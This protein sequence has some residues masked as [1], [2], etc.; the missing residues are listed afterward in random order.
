MIYDHNGSSSSIE[1]SQLNNTASMVRLPKKECLF[2]PGRQHSLLELI[3]PLLPLN[4][5][6]LVKTQ[7]HNSKELYFQ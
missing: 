7:I 3:Q 1:L 5:F 6:L 4:S 2:C